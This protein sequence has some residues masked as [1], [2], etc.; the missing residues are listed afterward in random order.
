[1]KKLFTL[2]FLFLAMVYSSNGLGQ[3]LEN[4][5]DRVRWYIEECVNKRKL[6]LVDNIFADSFRVHS[7]PDCSQRVSTKNDLKD[8]LNTLFEG[9]PDIHYIIGDI[10]GEGNKVAMRVSLRA[11]QEKE[12]LGIPSKR[13]KINYISEV[14]FFRFEN[15]RIAEDW[16]QLDLYNLFKKMKGLP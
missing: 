7:L 11:T 5:K 2:S 4:N 10:I 3:M 13:K 16:V 8:F 15:G 12:F 14:L 9:F 6:D 1:M